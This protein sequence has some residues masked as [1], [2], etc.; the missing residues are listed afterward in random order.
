MKLK[1]YLLMQTQQEIP[2]KF[3]NILFRIGLLTSSAYL[4]LLA[5]KSGGYFVKT[6]ISGQVYIEEINWP[7]SLS[8][9]WIPI[10]MGLLSMRV[11]LVAI[12]PSA[13]LHIEHDPEEEL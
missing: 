3:R 8:W 6:F 11:L 7:V 10:G 5:W 13:S 2:T 1:R 9:I 12:G 4:F